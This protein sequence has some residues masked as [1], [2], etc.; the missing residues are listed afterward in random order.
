M[1]AA[2]TSFIAAAS[3][4]TKGFFCFV[5]DIVG[6]GTCEENRVQ[7]SL[8]REPTPLE[9]LYKQADE[10]SLNKPKPSGGASLVGKEQKQTIIQKITNPAVERIYNTKEIVRESGLTR[11]EFEI[12]LNELRKELYTSTDSAQTTY[13]YDDSAVWRAISLSQ[14]ID[15]LSGI[16]ITNPTIR[17]SVTL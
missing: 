2:N 1:Q 7:A 11:D 3:E 17:I 6:I 14:K 5:T 10:T 16:T 15:N 8:T 12:A 9:I 4:A 13:I